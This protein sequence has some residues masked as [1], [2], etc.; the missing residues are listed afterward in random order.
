MTLLCARLPVLTTAELIRRRV[1]GRASLLEGLP[2]ELVEARDIP[3]T[4]LESFLK[5]L[6]SISDLPLPLGEARSS[7]APPS[8]H[9]A[10]LTALASLASLAS[11]ATLATLRTSSLTL[12]HA[13]RL[14]ACTL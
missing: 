5:S 10:S 11:L 12:G 3:L 9:P 14:T 6:D 7:P 1:R 2:R 13:L 4:L 8:S